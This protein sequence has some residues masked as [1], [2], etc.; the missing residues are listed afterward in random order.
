MVEVHQR[1]NVS[2]LSEGLEPLHISGQIRKLPP[3]FYTITAT[4]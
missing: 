3:R 4:Q 2:R 1:D